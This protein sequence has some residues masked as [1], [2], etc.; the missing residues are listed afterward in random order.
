MSRTVADLCRVLAAEPASHAEWTRLSV[1]SA[2]TLAS[3]PVLT[4]R[5]GIHLVF[6]TIAELDVLL[7]DPQRRERISA[8]AVVLCEPDADRVEHA[9]ALGLRVIAVPEDPRMPEDAQLEL[10]V[11]RTR[12]LLAVDAAAEARLV[13]SGGTVLTQVARRGGVEAVVVEL[14][15]RVQGWAVLLDTRGEPITTAGAARLHLGDAVALALKKPVRMRHPGMQVHAV[16][17]GKDLRAHLV[18]AARTG[19]TSRTRDLAA[20]AS[21]LLDL[22]LRTHDHSDIERLGRDTLVRSLSDGYP[23]FAARE[24]RAWGFRGDR[25][26]AFIVSSQSRSVVLESLVSHVLDEAGLP[27]FIRSEGSRVFGYVGV[28]ESAE[29]IAALERLADRDIVPLRCGVGAPA[30]L[31]RLADSLAQARDAHEVSVADRRAVTEF[32]HL[33]TVDLLL[34]TLDV[35]ARGRLAEPLRRIRAGSREADA[36]IDTVRMFLVEHGSAQATAVALGIHRHT[37]RARLERFEAVSGISLGNPDERFAL[38]MALRAEDHAE[39]A[40]D[41]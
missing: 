21:A 27:Q 36:L 33:P 14:A 30:A 9:G 18:V 37:L 2:V 22:L 40:A 34:G 4:D 11:A 24:L 41:A 31:D 12:E 26:R 23:G 8:A 7:G 6:A 16:G 5:D 20:Q 3:G 10:L 15:R 32:A 17:A 28:A 25:L 29:L 38:W 1:G 35:P 19:V 13:S 39:V